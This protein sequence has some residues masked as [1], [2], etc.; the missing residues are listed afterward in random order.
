MR[1]FGWGQAVSGLCVVS[2]ITARFS[3]RSRLAAVMPV[4]KAAVWRR[5]VH[6]HRVLL[7]TAVFAYL[8]LL[9]SY[10]YPFSTPPIK[11]VTKYINLSFIGATK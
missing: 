9:A 8:S 6:S 1:N 7:P 5:F 11:I 10:L 3:T 2:G 4:G